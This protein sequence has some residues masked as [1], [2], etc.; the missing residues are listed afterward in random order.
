MAPF[1]LASPHLLLHSRLLQQARHHL[2]VEELEE[3]LTGLRLYRCHSH[4]TDWTRSQ[5]QPV[6]WVRALPAQNVLCC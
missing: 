2:H 6:V 5:T 3:A 1:Q 4:N